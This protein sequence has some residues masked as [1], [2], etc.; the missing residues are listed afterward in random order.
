MHDEASTFGTVLGFA[1]LVLL[2][3]FLPRRRCPVFASMAISAF[4]TVFE[5]VRG[6]PA[7]LWPINDACCGANHVHP[8]NVAARALIISSLMQICPLK[9]RLAFFC[10]KPLRA[11]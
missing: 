11:H 8:A 3:A 5:S 9:K 10:G 6:V 2:S 7:A 4:G 1:I